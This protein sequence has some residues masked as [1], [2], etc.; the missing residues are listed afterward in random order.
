ML[1]CVGLVTTS[2]SIV[3]A[4][5]PAEDEAHKTLAVVKVAGLTLLLL[6]LGAGLYYLAESR[7]SSGKLS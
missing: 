7:R 5:V 2:L 6:G 3:L 1:A 4:L